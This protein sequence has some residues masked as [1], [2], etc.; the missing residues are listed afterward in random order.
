MGIDLV[1]AGDERC[2]VCAGDEPPKRTSGE[3]ST[4]RPGVKTMCRRCYRDFGQEL[5]VTEK[6]LD[7]V[8]REVKP[9]DDPSKN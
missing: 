9:P 6:F 8:H 7:P 2:D 1:P 3:R 5:W 4:A